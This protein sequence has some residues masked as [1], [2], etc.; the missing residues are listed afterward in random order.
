PKTSSQ[1]EQGA[2][3]A[4][5]V[6]SLASLGQGAASGGSSTATTDP[7]SDFQPINFAR[8]AN[9]EAFPVSAAVS[10]AQSSGALDIP[11]L[12]PQPRGWRQIPGRTQSS[13]PRTLPAARY[14]M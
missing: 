9:N 4:Q 3:L 8:P 6:A 11:Q 7:H 14:S 1:V 5:Q 13:S 12:K 10:V 2:T